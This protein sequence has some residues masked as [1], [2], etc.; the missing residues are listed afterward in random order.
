MALRNIKLMTFSELFDGRLPKTGLPFTLGW[1]LEYAKH[2]LVT[3][4]EERARQAPF[5]RATGFPHW[6]GEHCGCESESPIFHSPEKIDKYLKAFF[7]FVDKEKLP[8]GDMCGG[9][10]HVCVKKFTPR[11]LSRYL[12]AVN[13]AQ[14]FFFSMVPA[15]RQDN[16]YC[17]RI[18]QMRLRD[19]IKAVRKAAPLLIDGEKNYEK[20]VEQ[21][22]DGFRPVSRNACSFPTK[23]G[24]WAYPQPFFPLGGHC[25]TP[26]MSEA[27]KP[28]YGMSLGVLTPTPDPLAPGSGLPT[29]LHNTCTWNWIR[30]QP[31]YGT[32]EFR[33]LPTTVSMD[34]WQGY[35]AVITWFTY[36]FR[37]DPKETLSE[38]LSRSD[39]EYLKGALP[40]NDW[41]SPILD[42]L[43]SHRYNPKTKSND[44]SANE[45]QSAQAVA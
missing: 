18:P 24:H 17:T 25:H 42:W 7:E 41:P 32:L 3:H 43:F 26:V 6:K 13:L 30:H 1:E 44:G 10:L 20:V 40:F 22:P 4:L 39:D 34:E 31:E 21:F 12:I 27:I 28:R 35:L 19:Y 29:P 23:P 45:I 37:S 5:S 15:Y 33:L 8:F 11:D 2:C 38:I 14:N 16:R 9:H 36:K